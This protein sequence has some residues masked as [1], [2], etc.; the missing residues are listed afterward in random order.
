MKILAFSG[1]HG[2][3]RLVDIFIKSIVA[4]K[5]H[6]DLFVCAGD[7]GDSIIVDFFTKLS[8]F[9]CPILFVLGNHTL[10]DNRPKEVKKA[11]RI[12]Y[13]FRLSN[14]PFSLN[15][16]I[17]IGQDAWTHFTDNKRIDKRRYDDLMNKLSKVSGNGIILVTHHAP[18]G[19]FDRGVSYPEHSWIDDT[20]YYHGGSFSIRRIVEKFHP[21]IHIFAHCHSDGGKWKLLNNTLFVNVCHLERATRDGE[22]GING[23][24][25][26][27]DTD[28]SNCIPHHLSKVSPE[29]CTCG[30]I[31]FLNYRKCF[32]CYNKGKEI[33]D[34]S[35]IKKSYRV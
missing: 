6:P 25:M 19:I 30:A 33:I 31:H 1:L 32:N 10:L 5:L 29:K 9:E 4:K 26:V 28:A 23:S 34:F 18:L 2:N 27:I 16:F 20:G 8:R 17:F 3:K 15:N 13:V 14:R 11:E 35:E 7:I 24:F 21:S 12:P 22:I